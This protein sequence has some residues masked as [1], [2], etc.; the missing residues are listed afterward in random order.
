MREQELLRFCVPFLYCCS[1]F[2]V[3]LLMV[4]IRKVIHFT[5]QDVA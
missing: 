4:S 1:P 3:S 5:V 2:A